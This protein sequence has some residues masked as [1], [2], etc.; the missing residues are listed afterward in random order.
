MHGANYEKWG[1]CTGPTT[2]SPQQIFDFLKNGCM[3]IKVVA[4]CA[5]GSG[6][7]IASNP[8]SVPAVVVE[9]V[10]FWW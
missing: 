9:E 1:K 6:L 7:S 8:I 10:Q 5:P 4:K 3:N 2:I